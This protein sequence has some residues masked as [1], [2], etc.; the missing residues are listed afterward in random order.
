MD[1]RRRPL[2]G[3]IEDASTR[4]W[5]LPTLF[6][7]GTLLLLGSLRPLE[8]LPPS[9]PDRSVRALAHAQ[10]GEWKLAEQV[11]AAPGPKEDQGLEYRELGK[12]AEEQGDR[13]AALRFLQE[14]LRRS[15]GQD[16]P[17]IVPCS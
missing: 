5:G 11:A 16:D 15:S 2:R 7:L 14:S 17:R 12:F 1:A 9:L 6:A 8:A 4:A 13:A 3:F 10:K